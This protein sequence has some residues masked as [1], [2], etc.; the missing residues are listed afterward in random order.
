MKKMHYISELA[1]NAC[2]LQLTL[3]YF[4]IKVTWLLFPLA[5]LTSVSV[6]LDMSW[7]NGLTSEGYIV[8][9][10]IVDGDSEEKIKLM[11]YIKKEI[12]IYTD[13]II[14]QLL[15]SYIKGK[16]T[17]IKLLW[18]ILIKCVFLQTMFNDHRPKL[19]VQMNGIVIKGLVDTADNIHSQKS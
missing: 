3:V 11:T 14:V 9:T 2:I 6:N 5:T 18:E 4:L 16:A 7:K 12:Q 8:H 15:F 13:Y 1:P 17:L 10:G 19:M